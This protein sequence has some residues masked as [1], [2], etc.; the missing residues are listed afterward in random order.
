[1]FIDN[2]LFGVSPLYLE[3]IGTFFNA[4]NGCLLISVLQMDVY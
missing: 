3:S 4:T 2:L 1:M